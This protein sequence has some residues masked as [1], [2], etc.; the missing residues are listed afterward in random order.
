MGRAG[1]TPAGHGNGKEKEKEIDK[2]SSDGNSNVL[3]SSATGTTFLI[4]I[5]LASRIFT[6][7]SN[8]LILRT[9]SPIV[10]GIAAQLELF[11]VTILYFS[12]ESI[13]MAIQRQPLES[14]PS[15]TST[16]TDGKEKGNRDTDEKQSLASQSVVNVSYLSLFLGVTFTTGLTWFYK[17][18]APDQANATPFFNQ[19][20]T[21]TG[22]ASLL[23][24]TIEPFFAVVQQRM[25]YE[26]RAAV[27]LPAAFLKSL[28]TCST[29]FYA[30]RQGHDVG[31]LPFALGYMAYSLA[32]I[33]GYYYSLLWTP[34]TRQFSF[35]LSWIRPRYVWV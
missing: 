24:L 17:H 8:Q 35:L 28:V 12:R 14:S 18:F 23:E 32:L 21:V 22:L 34:F 25:W 33:F 15:S 31:P 30:A 1:K 27:E 6:F 9:L 2:T 16:S 19:S 10:L 13:R 3:R 20:V 4:I 29:F 26:K 5:Q 11:Q 7:A